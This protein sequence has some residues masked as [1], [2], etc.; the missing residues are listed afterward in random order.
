MYRPR[1]CTSA[2]ASLR[3]EAAGRGYGRILAETVA[4]SGAGS[5]PSPL[6]RPQDGDARRKDGRLGVLRQVQFLDRTLDAE[7]RKIEAERRARGVEDLALIRRKFS[8]NSLAMPTILR[9]LA[10]KEKGDFHRYRLTSY[11]LTG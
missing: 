4:G 9:T 7:L 3:V 1:F 8:M 11:L 2:T 10:G 5:K 6:E